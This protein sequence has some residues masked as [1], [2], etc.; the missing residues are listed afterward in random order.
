MQ[1]SILVISGPTASGKS[2]LLREVLK[3]EENFYFSISTTS[4]PKRDY[5]RDGVDYYFVSEE[6]FQK[7]IEN[8]LFLEWA[9]VH[10]NYY[11]TS[12]TPV[13]KAL[14]EG[15]LI[16]FDIDVQGHKSIRNKFKNI[17]TSL[18]V[19][20]PNQTILRERLIKRGTD[21]EEMIKIR[22][23]TALSEMTYIRDFDY[24]L[25]NDD[26]KESAENLSSIIKTARLKSKMGSLEDFLGDWLE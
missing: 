1:G 25:I 10:G 17:V 16:I 26:F 8:G 24:L 23:K 19:T 21:S 2:S 9:K 3:K 12:L 15:K 20:T 22:L 5:E 4:R 7:N 14:K 18:F 6:E 13:F 11:G